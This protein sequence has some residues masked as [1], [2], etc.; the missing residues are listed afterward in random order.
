MNE[1]QI[2]LYTDWSF[3]PD[4]STPPTFLLHPW[5]LKTGATVDIRDKSEFR[6]VDRFKSLR[7]NYQDY[8]VYTPKAE[9][10]DYAVMPSDWKYYR[11]LEKMH[12]GTQFLEL[13][14][15]IKKRVLVQYNADDD[16]P[17]DLRSVSTN[18]P[19]GP[20]VVRTSFNASKR[21][22]NEFVMPGFVGDPLAFYGGGQ[23]DIRKKVPL[24]TIS[25]CGWSAN[26]PMSDLEQDYFNELIED[27]FSALSLAEQA[28]L[29]YSFR[30]TVLNKIQEFGKFNTEFFRKDGYCG[31]IDRD[32]DSEGLSKVRREYFQS[33]NNSDYVVCIRGKGN[34]SYRFYE[35]LAWGRIPVFV[36]TDS[37]LPF[38]NEINWNDHCVWV[39]HKDVNNIGEIVTSHYQSLTPEGYRNLQVNN[40]KV[41]EEMLTLEKYFHHLFEV[42]NSEK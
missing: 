1:S 27:G 12:Q 28:K 5:H 19:A 22:P 35:T 21:G 14:Q 2:G 13:M 38:S 37:P 16:L 7:D 18:S 32:S 20:I 24:P 11:W 10:A 23:L 41:W 26:A 39:D 33:L 31:G 34:Y 15:Q 3:R 4:N 6:D 42:I 17:L 25:F 36:D 9:K 30:A 40:R 8:F 29:V